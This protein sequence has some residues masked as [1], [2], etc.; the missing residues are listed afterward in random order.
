MTNTLFSYSY[1][2]LAGRTVSSELIVGGE[3][4]DADRDVI[5]NALHEG[6]FFIASQV[7]LPSLQLRLKPH[8][9]SEDHIWHQVHPEGQIRPTKEQRTCGVSLATIVERFRSVRW[10]PAAEV[11][12]LELEAVHHDELG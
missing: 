6:R 11:A 2:D 10:D 12:T 1:R 9:T 7:G 3:V 8:L 5:R 4:R